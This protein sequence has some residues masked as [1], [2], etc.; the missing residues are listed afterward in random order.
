MIEGGRRGKK[1]GNETQ[2]QT[3][4][5]TVLKG[6]MRTGI[7]AAWSMGAWVRIIVV[8]VVVVVAVV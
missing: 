8:V 2:F 6:L 5:K 3:E 4:G 7:L 1:R